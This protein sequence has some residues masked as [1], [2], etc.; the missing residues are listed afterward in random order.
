VQVGDFRCNSD[1]K[2]KAY[3]FTNFKYVIGDYWIMG[4]QKSD[5]WSPVVIVALMWTIVSVVLVKLISLVIRPVSLDGVFSL[6]VVSLFLLPLGV[7]IQVCLGFWLA[8]RT[9]SLLPI[10]NSA[11]IFGV[12]NVIVSLA[13]EFFIFVILL[14]LMQ[15]NYPGEFLFNS[16]TQGLSNNPL[17][18]FQGFLAV[19]LGAFAILAISFV[20]TVVLSILFFLLGVVA[21]KFSR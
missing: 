3:L 8:K 21:Y 16:L 7:L 18:V 2:C 15:S 4:D 9:T 19:G 10:I 6:N 12:V 5:F 11:T 13:I 20:V 1:L 14:L 17:L